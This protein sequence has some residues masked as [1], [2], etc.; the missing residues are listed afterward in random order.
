MLDD[1]IDKKIRLIRAKEIQNASS[2]VSYS[3]VINRILHSQ[4]KK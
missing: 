1:D 4:L 2:S 3:G